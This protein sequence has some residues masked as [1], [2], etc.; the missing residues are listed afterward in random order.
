M[1]HQLGE[2]RHGGRYTAKQGRRGTR[3]HSCIGMS[4]LTQ[5]DTGALA[6]FITPFTA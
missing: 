1:G 5:L 6:F 3:G 2:L 4:A